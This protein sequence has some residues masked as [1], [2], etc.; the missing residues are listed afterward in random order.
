MKLMPRGMMSKYTGEMKVFIW[1]S[2]INS[3]GGALMWPLTTLFVHTQLNRSLA[4]AGFVILMQMLG[5]FFGQL[6]GG[7]LYYRLGV[8]RLLIG[9]LAATSLLQVSLVVT[10]HADW[11][12]YVTTMTV[13]GLTN[14]A[15]MPAIQSFVGFRW[16]DR[17]EELF[18]VIYVGNNVGVALGTALSGVLAD[19]SFNLTFVLNGLTSA[20][21]ALFFYRFLRGQNEDA[22]APGAVN[23]SAE[24]GATE[25]G[26]LIEGA[27]VDGVSVDGVSVNG[28][29][30]NGTSVNGVSV[31]GDSADGAGGQEKTTAAR[32]R[33]GVLPERNLW[34]KLSAYRIYLFMSVGTLFIWL[35]NSLWGTGVAP[36]IADQGMNFSM[37]SLLWTLNGVLIF[38]A[39]P[40]TSWMKRT[41]AV[42]L[43]SQL[44]W[45]AIF[46]GLAYVV[47]WF[48]PFYSGFLLAMALA[49]LGE[50]LVSPAVPAF[51]AARAGREAPFYMGVSG[52]I[53][54]IGRMIGPY[55]LGLTYD[56]GGLDGV[57]FISVLI[58]VLA[59]LSFVTHAALQRKERSPQHDMMMHG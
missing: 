14:S 23:G 41:I 55:V 16:A 12:L 7:G 48:L 10:A 40:I 11:W 42:P 35:A 9:A 18:N 8:R 56:H 39:Q 47:I 45:S 2:M 4:D 1:A 49:T 19:I 6:L 37:Y 34:E 46:Y 53:A 59:V 24:K 30:V 50:M 44:T 27:S 33:R 21:F 13:L 57:S 51:L 43:T 54:S 52:G 31:N 25:N 22:A 29:P 28:T 5:G 17:R 58:A 32:A 26:T 15:S 38:A 36:H 3:T 20:G